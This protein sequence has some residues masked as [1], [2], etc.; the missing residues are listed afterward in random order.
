M[1]HCS[2]ETQDVECDK[3]QDEA[4]LPGVGSEFADT[5][6]QTKAKDFWPPIVYASEE[7]EEDATDNHVVEMSDKEHGIVHLEVE[8]QP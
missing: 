2:H 3:C 7:S 8:A 1:S 4:N 6:V 5:A